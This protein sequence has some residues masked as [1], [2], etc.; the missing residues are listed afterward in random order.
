MINDGVYLERER[1]RLFSKEAEKKNKK[2]NTVVTNSLGRVLLMKGNFRIRR[3]TNNIVCTVFSC[4]IP[5]L[6]VI[7]PYSLQ[8]LSSPLRTYLVHTTEHVFFFFS[9]LLFLF[10]VSADDQ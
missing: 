2:N 5:I 7:E 4:S 1:H 8:H 3:T 9:L 10:P 6:V